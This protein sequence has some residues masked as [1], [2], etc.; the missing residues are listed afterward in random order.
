MIT[1]ASLD[2]N[3]Y[4]MEGNRDDLVPRRERS[5]TM[6]VKQRPPHL[7]LKKSQLNPIYARAKQNQILKKY[8][9]EDYPTN[10]DKKVNEVPRNDENPQCAMGEDDPLL[11]MVSLIEPNSATFPKFSGQSDRLEN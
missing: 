5:A 8:A 3:D 6:K 4:E 2:Y 7:G 11:G 9:V 10:V 1:E